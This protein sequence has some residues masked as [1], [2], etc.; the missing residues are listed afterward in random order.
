VPDARHYVVLGNGI[1]GTTAAETLRK[2]DSDCRI[3]LFTDEPYP[4]YNRVAL[5]PYLKGKT[6]QSKLF[7]KTM[8][9]HRER[10]ICLYP[11]TRVTNVDVESQTVVT[12]GS[13]ETH[14]DRLLVATGGTPSHLAVPGGDADGVCYFQ[15]LDDTNDLIERIMR[16]RSAVAI[17]GSYISYELAEGFRSRGLNVTWLIRGPRFL[18]RVLDNDGGDLVDK[19]ARHHGV[20]MVYEDTADHLETT[21]GR[22][23]AVVTTKQRRFEA[24][25]VGCGLG[26]IYNHSFLAPGSVDVG[27]GILTNEFLETNLDTV[28]AAGDI[29]DF[30]DPDL[31]KHYTMGTWA[32][33]TLHGRIAAQNM[34]GNRQPVHDVRQYTTTLFDSRM[35]VVGA[36]PEVR[37]EIDGVSR[38]YPKGDNPSD[39]SYRR[40]FFFEKRLVGAALIG[41]MHAKV[42]LVK[43]IRAKE[44][45]WGDRER[46]LSL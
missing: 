45:V 5:P 23:A 38:V 16:A 41:D 8:E 36:T 29:A 11:S 21:G 24:D 34:L 2:S 27:Y 46:L 18:H 22:V 6:P 4:L 42:D 30:Y 12:D 15:T 31:D 19:I 25:L 13:M 20:D 3:S 35:T 43:T 7:M 28:F 33:A 32:S 37:P 26:L 1:A 39:W 44:E 14:Y 10:N 17:G 9:F 40:L